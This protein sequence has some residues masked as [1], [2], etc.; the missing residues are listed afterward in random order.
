MENHPTE[1][2]WVPLLLTAAGLF[3]GWGAPEILNTPTTWVVW[4][5]RSVA[6]VLVV[7]AGV[8]AYRILRNRSLRKGGRGGAARVEGHDSEAV[9]GAGGSSASGGLAG[10]GGSA[11]VK[12]NRSRARGG[13][14]GGA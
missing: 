11:S 8:L 2:F 13:A 3:A 6:V 14:G 4:V 9:G 12:G 7:A 5:C 1:S 10:D